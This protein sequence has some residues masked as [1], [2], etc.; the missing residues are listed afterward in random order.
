MMQVSFRR[1]STEQGA[2]ARESTVT[3]SKRTQTRM[4]CPAESI[5]GVAGDTD[6]LVCEIYEGVARGST[7][8][9][10]VQRG[11]LPIPSVAEG[12]NVDFGGTKVW[13][14]VVQCYIVFFSSLKA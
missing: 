4:R 2:L 7:G 8:K 12:E 1:L 9:S 3:R 11:S 5:L 13:V 10:L 14:Y 6:L